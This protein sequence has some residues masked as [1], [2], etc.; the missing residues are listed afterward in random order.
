MFSGKYPFSPTLK[1]AVSDIAADIKREMYL[2]VSHFIET[3]FIGCLASLVVSIL[4][5]GARGHGLKSRDAH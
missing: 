4:D 1:S 2:D 3:H 5:F